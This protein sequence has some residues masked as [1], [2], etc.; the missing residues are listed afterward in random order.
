MSVQ[1]KNEKPLEQNEAPNQ[2]QELHAEDTFVHHEP[3]TFSEKIAFEFVKV[4]AFL[5]MPFLLNDTATGPL[6]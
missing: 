3:Q 1:H 5:Q 2:E 4:Y 6:C